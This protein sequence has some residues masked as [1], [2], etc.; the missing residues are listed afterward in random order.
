M[1]MGGMRFV[2][3]CVVAVQVCLASSA[4][5]A[6]I[7]TVNSLNDKHDAAIN[8]VCNDGTGACTLRAAIE[9]ANAT[10]TLDTINL[11]LGNG[12]PSIAVGSTTG[13]ALPTIIQPVIING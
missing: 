4:A 12:T 11:S 1:L 3:L 6:A 8:G 2:Y 5:R 13:I 10:V 7:F 9:E